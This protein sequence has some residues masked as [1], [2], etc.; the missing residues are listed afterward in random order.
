MPSEEPA[1]RNAPREASRRPSPL[2]GALALLL[3]PLANTA[4]VAVETYDQAV[5]KL[6]EARAEAA[7]NDARSA[8][9][10]SE[11]ARHQGE[12]ARLGQELAARD[13]RL[14][15]LSVARANDAKKLDE[16]IAFNDELAQ[17]LRAAGKGAEA[18]AGEKGSLAKALADTNARLEELRRMQATAEAR[19]AELRD[20]VARFRN[21]TDAGQLK[22]VVRGGRMLLELPADILFQPGKTDISEAGRRTLS[23]VAQ[24]LKTMPDRS[25]QVGSH[26]DNGKIPTARFPSN[27]ELSTARAVVVVKLLLGAGMFPKDLSAAGYGEGAPVE[28][29]DT[30][31]GRAKNRRIE[32]VLVPNLE[33]LVAMPNVEALAPARGRI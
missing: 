26:T 33:E 2:L 1:L 27:W 9:L 16:L 14:E 5:A 20:L 24:V 7:Q 31:E 17:R 25:F 4:C 18:L 22:A 11:V 21:M 13:A 28:S 32:I 29:N 6:Q 12:V 23:E 30:P 10:A 15:D 8:A 19:A 3:L